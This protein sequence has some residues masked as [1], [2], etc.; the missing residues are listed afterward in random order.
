MVNNANQQS[1][2]TL[3]GIPPTKLSTTLTIIIDNNDND[4]E[5]VS[6]NGLQLHAAES[7]SRVSLDAH[8][9]LTWGVVSGV[10]GCGDSKAQTH[11]H[12]PESACVE[13]V[14]WKPDRG[15]G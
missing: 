9:P 12:G 6:I 13:S 1:K 8:D 4:G 14:A 5:V 15:N 3:Q 10:E 2:P 11:P 7:K